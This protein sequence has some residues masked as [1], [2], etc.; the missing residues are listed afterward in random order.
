MYLD[1]AEMQITA[2]VVSDTGACA[3]LGPIGISADK[4]S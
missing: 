4:L 3:I 1:P 2:K